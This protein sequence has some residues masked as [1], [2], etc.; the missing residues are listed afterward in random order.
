MGRSIQPTIDPALIKK[1][2]SACEKFHKDGQCCPA[3]DIIATED[4][5][6]GLK[7]LRLIDVIGRQIITAPQGCRYVAL[8][9]Q[10]GQGKSL[11]FTSQ[12][13][14]WFA[15]GLLGNSFYQ[16]LIPRTIRDA[17]TLV[18]RIGERYLW[19]DS[20]CLIQDNDAD[21]ADGN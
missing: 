15:N 18:S 4:H 19:V 5:P 3:K 21:M 17:I 8:S 20:L 13:K 16:E 12:S 2:L 7:T 6:S 9:Y 10:W 11:L 14:S 1:W